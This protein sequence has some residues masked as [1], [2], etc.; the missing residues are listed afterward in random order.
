MAL[1]SKLN[2]DHPS[3][4]EY[5]R[6][7][8]GALSRMGDVLEDT[9]RLVESRE[10]YLQASQILEELAARFPEVLRHRSSLVG[11]LI[12]LGNVEVL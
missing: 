5:R 9:R 4:V 1:L 6:A 8:A 12:N 7:L 11:I 2:A 10:A 3:E